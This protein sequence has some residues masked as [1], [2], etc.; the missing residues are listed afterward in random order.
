MKPSYTVGLVGLTLT[1][2][3]MPT[4]ANTLNPAY[5]EG[6]WVGE[7]YTCVT[8]RGLVQQVQIEVT[9][10]TVVARKLDGDRCVPV[11]HVTFQGSV[12]QQLAPGV[13][14]PITWTE[15]NPRRPASQ[16]VVDT[17][18]IQDQNTFVSGGITFTRLN[19]GAAYFEGTWVGDG[20]TCERGS[21]QVQRVRIEVV[22]DALVARK[23][24]GDRCVPAGHVTFQ[25]SVPE[26]VD[27]GLSHPVTWTV[28]NPRRPASQQIVDPILIEDQNT[29]SSGGITF[30]RQP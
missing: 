5:F 19:A 6:T 11:G 26:R 13:P 23:L 27:P 24:D 8:D 10:N 21:N 12:P 14:L 28:G 30:T 9:G 2:T 16:Q 25:G 7:G 22:D 1:A 15:G 4:M 18:V 20:Y 17:L 3:A 29:F